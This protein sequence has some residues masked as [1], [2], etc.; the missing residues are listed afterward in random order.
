M[1]RITLSH[2]HEKLRDAQPRQIVEPGIIEAAVALVLVA[3]DRGDP[4][5]LLL[6]RAE[7]AGDPW[8]GQ[9]A[10]PGGR[11][12]RHDANLMQTARRETREE[13]GID[14]SRVEL[15]GELDDL[16]PRTPVLPPVVV[17]P[18]VFA[19]SRRPPIQL[20]EEAEVHLW[21]ALGD[22]TGSA[23]HATVRVR[24]EDLTVPAYQAGAHIVWGMTHRI[25]KSLIDLL[26]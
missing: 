1:T 18:F 3:D 2:V 16:H 12:D 8:S 24:G 22:L 25:I 10:L 19:L 4:E 21:I 26:E 13:T 6:K 20:N 7:R 11:R 15:L 17:R 9:M 23:T 5:L 14:L